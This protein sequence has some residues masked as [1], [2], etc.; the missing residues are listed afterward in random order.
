MTESE[1]KRQRGRPTAGSEHLIAENPSGHNGRSATRARKLKA[2]KKRFL[3]KIAKGFSVGGAATA[4]Q[5][6]R[7]T[8]YKWREVDADFA[9]AWDEHAELGNDALEDE[10]RRRAMNGI[11]RPIYQNGKLVGHVQEYSDRLLEVMLRSRRPQKFGPSRDEAQPPPSV[12]D[13]R[14]SQTKIGLARRVA[15]VLGLGIAAAMQQ[16]GKRLLGLPP[17]PQ[18]P[19]YRD[20]PASEAVK[21]RHPGSPREV[22]IN[23]RGSSSDD[24]P[25]FLN[26]HAS[27]HENGVE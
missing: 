5:V 6:S 8:P 19:V 17:P 1:K 10:G 23:P 13:L 3:A 9:A 18:D 7:R 16:Q 15:Y 24:V 26:P 12:N 2:Q 27:R 25:R 22:E 20:R 14:D 21:A 4:A 11:K